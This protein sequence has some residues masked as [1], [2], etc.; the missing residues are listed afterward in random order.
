M[1]LLMF[2]FFFSGASFS[3]IDLRT[4]DVEDILFNT[5]TLPTG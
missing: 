1:P 3:E 5:T 4:M 2:S